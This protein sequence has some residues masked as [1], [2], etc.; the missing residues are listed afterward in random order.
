[1]KKYRKPYRIKKKKQVLSSRFIRS[2]VLIFIFL[3]L[4]FYFL[5]FSDFFSVKKLIIT[6]HKKISQDQIKSFILKKNIFLTAVKEAEENIL[7]DFPQIARVKIDRG[8]PDILRIEITERRAVAVWCEDGC[9]LIDAEGIAFEKTSSEADFIKI[10]GAKELIE[11]EGLSRLFEVQA[12]LEE[13]LGL[14]SNKAFFVSEERLN[15]ETAEGWQIYFN[16]KGDIDWQ[17]T[18]LKLALEKEIPPEKRGNL[19][20]IDLRFSRIY[21]KYR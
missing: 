3:S 4:L 11:K 8:L 20:Y 14:S 9:F 17:I 21:Y 19:E 5:F 1:M 15:I 18:E 7:S 6:G 10:F 2:G 12:K 16:L 13:S